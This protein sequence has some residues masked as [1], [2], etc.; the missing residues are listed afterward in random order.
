[1]PTTLQFVSAA[2]DFIDVPYT[3][4]GDRPDIA[5]DCIQFIKHAAKKCGARCDH[6]DIPPYGPHADGIYMETFLDEN[7]VKVWELDVNT[8]RTIRNVEAFKLYLKG[9]D[10]ICMG[11]ST[12]LQH[13]AVAAVGLYGWNIIHTRKDFGKVKEHSLAG[14]WSAMVRAIYRLP[15]VY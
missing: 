11:R 1:M 15:D 4:L 9:G 5:L 7:F 14:K 6:W 2:R 8:P 3:H 12:S 13:P 10:I